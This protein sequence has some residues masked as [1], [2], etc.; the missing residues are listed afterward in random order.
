GLL[1]W[2]P[3]S[4]T[5]SGYLTSIPTSSLS[6]YLT[7]DWLSDEH[8]SVMLEI[9]GKDVHELDRIIIR[10]ALFYTILT[11]AYTNRYNYSTD[12]HYDWLRDLGIQ[13]RTEKSQLLT[14]AHLADQHHWV[15][16]VIDFASEQIFIGDSMSSDLSIG[17]QM[18]CVLDW[19]INAHMLQ[20]FTYHRLP[21]T[22]QHDGYSCGLLAWNAIA[23][24]LD[25]E[26]YTLISPLQVKDERI[27]VLLTLAR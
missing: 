9:L 21:I 27:Q 22:V 16:V 12:H 1:S 13:L 25:P 15:A 18:R 8:E 5:L 6:T 17:S 26:R 2:L 19:W 7:I 10:D 23:H 11:S 3:W 14:I 24:H 4:G 20:Q